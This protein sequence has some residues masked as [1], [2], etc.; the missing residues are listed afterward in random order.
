[1]ITCEALGL[2]LF[3]LGYT[4]NITFAA[5]VRPVPSSCA[6]GSHFIFLCTCLWIRD[7]D[8]NSAVLFS[9]FEQTRCLP[10]Q[11]GRYLARSFLIDDL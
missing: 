2:I 11:P 3:V 4:P 8:W 9:G 10:R 6:Y 1:M 5:Y 7:L